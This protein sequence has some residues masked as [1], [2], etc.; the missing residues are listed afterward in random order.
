MNGA[1][2]MKNQ[3]EPMK[4]KNETAALEGALKTCRD[5]DARLSNHIT[6]TAAAAREIESL[7]ATIDIDSEAQTGRAAR[8]L[9]IQALA[10]GRLEVLREEL[11]AAQRALIQ[12]AGRFTLDCFAPRYND[13]ERR[14]LAKVEG[15]IGA[16]YS[17]PDLLREA[18]NSSTIMRELEPMEKHRCLQNYFEAEAVGVAERLLAGWSALV[19]FEEEHLS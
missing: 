6:K 5:L 7:Q 15:Q 2:L 4:P 17:D 10:G 11:E 12:S 13:V 16:A 1:R 18:A 14:A 9:A 19:R 3:Q 8:L